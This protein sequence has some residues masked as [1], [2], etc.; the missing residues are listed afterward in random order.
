MSSPFDENM[1]T[2][3]IR[4]QQGDRQAMGYCLKVLEK[5][6]LKLVQSYARFS[7][8]V[9]APVSKQDLYN[10]AVLF[11]I[12]HI[13]RF[14]PDAE[15]PDQSV[16]NQFARYFVDRV[17]PLLREKCQQSI[18]TVDM[19]EW[20][21]KYAQRINKAIRELERTQGHNFTLRQP[22]PEKVAASCG[23]PL[24]KVK[25]YIKRG[26]HLE[27]SQQFMDVDADGASPRG[28]VGIDFTD[29]DLVSGSGYQPDRSPVSDEAKAT[30]GLDLVSG[31]GS[32]LEQAS[33]SDET[34]RIIAQAWKS[35]NSRQKQVLAMRF[36][37]GCDP[38]TRRTIAESLN[39]SDHEVR[40]A[41]ST[42]MATIKDV[43]DIPSASIGV[44]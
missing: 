19:P 36:G 17:R 28:G 44:A 11:T 32:Q 38:C 24:S 29:Q 4:A 23:A 30:I 18:R 31:S 41:E 20:A 15:L 5:P 8:R 12:E 14:T 27:P 7:D 25:L 22:D 10:E 43:I 16:R 42:G 21:T 1:P 26:F 2:A 39:L 34:K 9:D 37:F 13:S 3:I 6:L 35:L 33:I 40:E